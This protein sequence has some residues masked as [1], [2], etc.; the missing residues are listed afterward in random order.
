MQAQLVGNFAQHQR[1][2]GQLTMRK[3]SFLALDDGGGHAQDGVKALLNVLD[4]P[5]RLLQPLLQ[6]RTALALVLLECVGINIVHAQLGHDLAIERD[7]EAAPGL[8]HQHVGHDHVT[9]DIDKAPAR[10]RVEPADE[11]DGQLD[12]ALRKTAQLRQPLDVAFGQQLHGLL[13]NGDGGARFFSV[14]A[15]QQLQAQTLGQV[16]RADASRL[17]VMQQLERDRKMMFELFGLL[18]I[19]TGQAGSQRSQG[20]FEIAVVVE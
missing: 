19:F 14:L 2:H 17:H 20:V 5:A 4:E 13:A 8:D 15:V 1:A 10:L 3:E 7:L 9:L 18:Q 16:A 12:G 11:A 6:G